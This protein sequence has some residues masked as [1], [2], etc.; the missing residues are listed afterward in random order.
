MRFADPNRKPSDANTASQ[1]AISFAADPCFPS[2]YA[3]GRVLQHLSRAA[4][5]DIIRSNAA[6]HCDLFS[7]ASSGVS[8]LIASPADMRA[9]QKL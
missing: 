2:A 8:D 4:S 5:S 7:H 9:S 1:R 3:R 6:I